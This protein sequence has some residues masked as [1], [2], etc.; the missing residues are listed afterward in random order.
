MPSAR[1]AA[2]PP[3]ASGLDMERV[4][5]CSLT[6]SVLFRLRNV[7]PLLS[8]LSPLVKATPPLLRTKDEPV[9]DNELRAGPESNDSAEDRALGG[10]AWCSGQSW[11]GLRPADFS[12]MKWVQGMSG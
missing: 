6:R 10:I 7:G 5:P 4:S 1:F 3:A 12:H 8:S 9:G 2:L 11:S